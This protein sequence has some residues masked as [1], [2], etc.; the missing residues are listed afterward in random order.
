V[1]VLRTSTDDGESWSSPVT[2]LQDSSG[3]CNNQTDNCDIYSEN[4]IQ[5]SNGNF[6]VWYHL[7]NW[8]DEPCLT[9]GMVSGSLA[10]ITCTPT[11][12]RPC[13]LYDSCRKAAGG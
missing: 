1:L 5:A 6:V 4:L 7:S 8:R 11:R 13:F 9:H 3:Q 12:W 2:L 10:Y